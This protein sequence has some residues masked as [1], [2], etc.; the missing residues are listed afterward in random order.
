M[1]S[2]FVNS[3]NFGAQH[4]VDGVELKGAIVYGSEVGI[5]LGQPSGVGEIGG[6]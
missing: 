5:K 1:A 6:G 3:A 4:E 2:L